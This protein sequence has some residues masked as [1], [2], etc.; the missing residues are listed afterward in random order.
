M[1]STV[2]QKKGHPLDA[3]PYCVCAYLTVEVEERLCALETGY[4]LVLIC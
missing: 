3:P 1:N 2:L 4:L